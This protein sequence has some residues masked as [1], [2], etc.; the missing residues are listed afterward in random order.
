[1]ARPTKQARRALTVYRPVKYCMTSR[2]LTALELVLNDVLQNDL[3]ERQVGDQ[4]P[5]VPILL[6]ELLQLAGFT[7]RHPAIDLLLAVGCLLG[8][9]DLATDV[10]GLDA[11]LALLQNRGD[12]LDGKALLLH[13]TPSW[14]IKVQA[15]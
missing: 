1:M 13:G 12:L 6:A 8:D 9:R 14:S 4:A 3:V 10:Q 5:Q 7:R 15:S 2:C 11:A